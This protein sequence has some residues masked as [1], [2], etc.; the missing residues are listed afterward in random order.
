MSSELPPRASRST[1]EELRRIAF[2]RNSTDEERAAATRKLAELAAPRSASSDSTLAR[3]SDDEAGTTEPDAVT[4]LPVA[5]SSTTETVADETASGAQSASARRRST[6][7]AWLLPAVLASLLLGAIAG[8]ATAPG[9]QAPAPSSTAS[10]H[11]PLNPALDPDSGLVGGLVAANTWLARTP[12]EADTFPKP[13][14]AQIQSLSSI[15][16]IKDVR[17]NDTLIT[18]WGAKDPGD[19]ICLLAGLPGGFFAT[20]CVPP[21]VFAERGITLAFNGIEVSWDGI[22]TSLTLPRLEPKN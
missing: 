12:T 14:M 13:S 3:S 7:A 11:R 18:V 22:A 15:R 20:T 1:A 21:K 17:D 19:G 16:H 5:L 2:G 9:L 8:R 10:Q 4:G 6:A